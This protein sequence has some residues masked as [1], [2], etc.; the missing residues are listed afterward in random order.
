MFEIKIFQQICNYKLKWSIE[1]KCL[2]RQYYSIPLTKQ[3]FFNHRQNDSWSDFT[4]VVFNM[5]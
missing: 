1:Q 2:Y 4:I 3:T 5:F